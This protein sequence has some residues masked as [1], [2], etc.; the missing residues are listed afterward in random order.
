MLSEGLKWP[1]YCFLRV[2]IKD[3][4]FT[5]L[6]PIIHLDFYVTLDF[7]EFYIFNTYSYK[8]MRRPFEFF[9]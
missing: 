9:G 4:E 1:S 6:N 3:I 5:K 7:I 2:C 8:T